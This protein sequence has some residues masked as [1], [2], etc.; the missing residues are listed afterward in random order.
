MKILENSYIHTSNINMMLDQ[1]E[2]VVEMLN[3]ADSL[4]DA[5]LEKAVRVM[6]NGSDD[7]MA[8]L[9]QM[10]VSAEPDYGVSEYQKH[11]YDERTYDPFSESKEPVTEGYI[12]DRYLEVIKICNGTIDV[13]ELFGPSMNSVNN[14]RA[15]IVAIRN[16]LRSL[17]SGITGAAEHECKLNIRDEA[18][19][20]NRNIEKIDAM[21]GQLQRFKAQ[22]IEAALEAKKVTA[23]VVVPR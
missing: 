4:E 16:D 12:E 15:G 3:D 13:A 20:I 2:E 9:T 19:I 8:R 1:I 6:Y 11:G 7:V 5:K 21:I 10:E 17:K 18:T 22:A 23:G 14:I